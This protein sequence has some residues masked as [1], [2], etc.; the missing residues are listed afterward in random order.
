MVIDFECGIETV[1]V[2]DRL[3]I[4]VN[5]M[6]HDRFIQQIEMR[7]FS[8]LSA[9][10]VWRWNGRWATQIVYDTLRVWWMTTINS[11]SGMCASCLYKFLL[12]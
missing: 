4:D 8:A 6:Q 1:I 9:F 11:M 7:A 3:N 10:K 12:P 2:D 5:V